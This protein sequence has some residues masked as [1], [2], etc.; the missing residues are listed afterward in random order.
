MLTVTPLRPLRCGACS[1]GG[2][3]GGSA[4]AQN[5]VSCKYVFMWGLKIHQCIGIGTV[6][7]ARLRIPDKMRMHAP[8]ARV[9]THTK[10]VNADD[11]PLKWFML[12]A[13]RSTTTPQNTS[14]WA[15]AYGKYIILPQRGETS[16]RGWRRAAWIHQSG[17][18]VFHVRKMKNSWTT[19][20][21]VVFSECESVTFTAIVACCLRAAHWNWNKRRTAWGNGVQGECARAHKKKS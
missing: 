8:R 4:V 15:Y 1:C 19:N 12:C 13:T 7:S 6:D 5:S 14:N 17:R 21:C 18:D 2:D 20:K 16:G 10:S 3:V 9:H 11:M